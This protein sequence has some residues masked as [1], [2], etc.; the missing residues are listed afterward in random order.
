MPR[1]Q[2]DL[3]R[4]DLVFRVR[5]EAHLLLVA[6]EDVVLCMCVVEVKGCKVEGFTV[7]QRHQPV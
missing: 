6:A 1:F 5:E 4:L 2:V 3:D 7:M